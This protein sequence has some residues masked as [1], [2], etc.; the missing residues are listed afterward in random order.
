MILGSGNDCGDRLGNRVCNQL[1]KNSY[2]SLFIGGY[3]LPLL[4]A[5]KYRVYLSNFFVLKDAGNC[6]MHVTYLFYSCFRN[7]SS[8]VWPSSLVILVS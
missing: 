4:E 1:N 7:A 3:H 6:R 8:S 2:C 5:L